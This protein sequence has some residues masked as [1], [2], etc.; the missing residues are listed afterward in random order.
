MTTAEVPRYSTVFTFNPFHAFPNY[1]TFAVS[2]GMNS[3]TISLY[4]TLH[5]HWINL[6]ASVNPHGTRFIDP[7]IIIADGAVIHHEVDFSGAHLNPF[8]DNH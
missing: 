1:E 2:Y 5:T 7:D 8:S 6:Q 4:Q 3:N